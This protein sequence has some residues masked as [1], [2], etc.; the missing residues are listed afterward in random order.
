M[1]VRLV[2][3]LVAVMAMLASC[4]KNDVPYP[5]IQA[6][7]KT[8]VAEGQEKA[9]LIDSTNC[10]VTLY[11][12]EMADLSNIT[13][14]EYSITPGATVEGDALT[15]VLNL[16]KPLKV[17]LHIYQS[18][19][20]TI[21]AEQNIERYFSVTGQ[22][23]TS[24]IDVPARRIVVYISDKIDL[25]KV[26]VERAKLGPA[27]AI[28][29][30]ELEGHTIDL[31]RPLEVTVEAFGK[32][33]IWN[34]F[35]EQTSLSVTTAGVDAWTNVAWVRGQA[36]A[37]HDNGFDYREAGTE[38]WIRV[39][40]ADVVHDGG[41]F[42]ARIIHLLPQT[43]YEVRAYSDEDLGEV[44]S[45]TTGSV[46]QL[47]NSGI[48]D[49]WLDDKVWCP[50][51]EGDTPYWD[52]GNKGATTIGASNSVPTDDTATGRGRAAMLE[53]KFVGLGVLGKLAAGNLFIGEYYKTDG[54]NGILHFGREF[55]ERPTKLRGYLKYKTAPIDYT[56]SGLEH[57]A[58]RPDTCV[59][60]CA[61]ID[62]NSQFEIRT[63]PRNRQL[64]D[65]NGSY[66]VAFGS[67]QYGEDVNQY[68]QFEVELEYKSTSRV[69]KYILVTASASKYGDY[70]TGGTGAVLY[71]DELELL[72]DY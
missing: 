39:D 65:P 19:T 14:Q 42:S 13:V 22:I 63:N 21:C 59:V 11:F 48:D 47:P 33:E 36:E 34:I 30:P 6:N 12:D 58:G 38:E 27:G 44:L 2:Y 57:L 9:A 32:V 24:Y 31:S 70:F 56:S 60:W 52:T 4:I 3:M 46:V 49:W 54:T 50:W 7:F 5:R 37:G 68:T 1:R 71:L 61:L 43:T 18:W 40:A 17:N 69:P 51:A 45:F 62:Q 10:I 67:V 29:T 16:T 35:A 25:S 53:T 72:Y 20:W 66:V 64:F 28:I 55:T 23:G 15:G 26:Y 41:D 8:F